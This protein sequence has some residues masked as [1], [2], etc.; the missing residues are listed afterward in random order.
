MPSPTII[1]EASAEAAA[2]TAAQRIAVLVRER[3]AEKR[4]CFLALCGG[5]TPSDTYRRLA[6]TPLS[7]QVPWGSVQIFF[8]DERDVPQDDVENNYRTV[9]K[10]LLDHVPVPLAKVHPM[11][12][13][14]RDLSAA[15]EQYENLIRR[16][17]PAGNG[18][19]C[20][21]LILLGMGAEGHI[22][23]LFPDTPALAETHRLVT[24][25]FVPVIGRNRMTFTFP[26]INAARTVM[27]LVT[28]GDKAP[29]VA[30]LL[31]DDAEARSRY[32]AAR[33]QPT[34]G[35]LIFV[36]DAAAA[37]KASLPAR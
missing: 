35:E 32:P 15:S 21:D 4:D 9:A 27:F 20:F 31:S 12:A 3:A 33:V 1:V 6:A 19:P 13:D 14:C 29:A 26:L 22:A 18:I 34:P 5:T 23:S 30:A 36:L 25:Q 11:P 24:A 7:E 8:G 17:V 37:S 2:E 28:G 10:T 16:L